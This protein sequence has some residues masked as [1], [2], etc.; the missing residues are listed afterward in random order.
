MRGRLVD[1][2]PCLSRTSEACVLYN[3]KNTKRL[4]HKQNLTGNEGLACSNLLK[5]QCSVAEY[6]RSVFGEI[7]L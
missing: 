5:C 4:M 7:R 1:T 2:L 3:D 6:M